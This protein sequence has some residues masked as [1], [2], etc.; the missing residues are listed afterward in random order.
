M[1]TSPIFLAQSKAAAPPDYIWKSLVIKKEQIEAE[2]QRLT[3]LPAIAG[4][5]R[6]RSLIVHPEAIEPGLGFAPGITLAI[7]VLLPSESTHPARENASQVIF[8]VRGNGRAYV[9]DRTIDFETNDAWNIPSMALYRHENVGTSPLVRFVYS[10]EALLEKL[11][12]Y[13]M[14]HGGEYK[15]R[16]RGAAAA[17]PS[18]STIR[19]ND[20][21]AELLPYELLIAPKCG[22]R[23]HCIGRGIAFAMNSIS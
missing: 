1:E 12:I 21:G 10:N 6:R 9:N 15:A 14:E 20:D 4:T 22:C 7:E 17:R 23:R 13:Y 11:G 5:A 16:E 3:A 18:L 8:C 19:V 2:I